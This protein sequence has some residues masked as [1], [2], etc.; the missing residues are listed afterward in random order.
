MQ[1]VP[2]PEDYVLYTKYDDQWS[3]YGSFPRRTLNEM[4]KIQLRELKYTE[5]IV[6][7]A[8]LDRYIR[9]MTAGYYMSKGKK[10]IGRELQIYIDNLLKEDK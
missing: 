4:D 8:E 2:S 6:I 9:H 7:P 1:R 5:A 10:A 3:C